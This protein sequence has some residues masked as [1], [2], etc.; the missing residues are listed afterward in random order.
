MK[1]VI[2]ST[3]KKLYST[4]RLREAAIAR[5]H[6]VRIIHP[7]SCSLYIEEG[8]PAMFVKGKRIGKLDAVIPRIASSL[9]YYGTAVVRQFEQMGIFCLN[10]S[11]AIAIARDKLRTMQILSR[12][13]IGIPPTAFVSSV[14]DVAAAIE[15]VGK[16]PVVI[17]LLAGTQGAGVMLAESQ[18]VAEAIVS[19]L[20]VSNQ[21]VIIQKFIAE[22]RGKDIRAFV[23][24]DK[25]VAAMRR[26]AAIDE[27]FRSNVH[28]GGLTEKID[29][30]PSYEKL[31]VRAAQILG[32]HVVGVDLLE[33]SHGPMI[34]ELNAS[35][36]LEGIET[37]T[38]VAVAEKIIEFLEEQVSFP[39][40]DVRER[41]SLSRGYSIVEVPVLKES[42]L[43][44]KT[45]EQTNLSAQGIQVLSITR[46]N[47]PIP[48]PLPSEKLY[49]RDVLLMFGKQLS[50]RQLFPE[51]AQG[52]PNKSGREQ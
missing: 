12:H 52:N 25:V 14:P 49:P 6:K 51:R 5:G 48:N 36:G 28:L 47:Q 45:L 46:N 29:L 23:V 4:K 19:A 40:I 16:P 32:L 17:K 20:K 43:A 34:M 27:E 13:H 41:L 26:T 50:L 37:A 22:S 9:T 30:D 3:D 39:D 18:K 24:G 15:H 21:N 10:S 11:Y 1:I 7:T 44:D 31:A 42:P 2:L 38:Q 35:P 8:K 33:S